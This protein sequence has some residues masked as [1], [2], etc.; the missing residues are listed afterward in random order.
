M[1]RTQTAPKN[2]FFAA[3]HFTRGVFRFPVRAVVS[4]FYARSILCRIFARGRVPVV[5]R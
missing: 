3:P 5:V 4:K 1:A 2:G